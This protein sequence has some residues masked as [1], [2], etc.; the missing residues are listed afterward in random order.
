MVASAFPASAGKIVVTGIGLSTALGFGVEHNWKRLL[1]GESAV[2]EQPA[3]SFPLPLTMPPVLAARIDRAVLAARIREAVPRQIWNTSE[4]CCHLWLLTALE[5]LEQAGLA[6][7][8]NI[9]PERVGV[10]AGTGAGSAQFTEQEFINIFTAEKA[11]HRDVSRL[12]VLKYMASSLAGQLSL[13]RG[14]RGPCL[15]INT[16]CASGATA[17]LTALDALRLGRVD[18]AVAGGVDLCV[19]GGVIKGFHKLGALTMRTELGA[20][21]CRPF[22]AE[23]DG[24][25]LGDGAGCLVLE[26][27]ESARKRGRPALACLLGG[28]ATSDAFSLLAPREDGTDQARTMVLAL[29]DAG[30]PAERVAHVYAHGTGTRYNDAC[31]ARALEQV[32]GLRPTLSAT[33]ALLGHTI[34]A[35]GA[36]DAVLA[37]LSLNAGQVVPMIHLD[38]PDPDCAISPALAAEQPALGKANRAAVLVNSFAFGGHNACLAFALM[39]PAGKEANP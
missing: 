38:A 20:R 1:A 26:R 23:R 33:K 16:A 21:A 24:I 17:L 18:C 27:E 15:T 36:I 6:E 22:A 4:E 2:A 11:V 13:L 30:L 12:A 19:V 35:A 5:A 34:G 31:E 3:E 28:A 8:D 32:C 14:F 10:Y 9:P 7:Q 25:A 37:V 29:D 39:H